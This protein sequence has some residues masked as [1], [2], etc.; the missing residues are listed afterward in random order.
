MAIIQNHIGPMP[1]ESL[2]NSKSEIYEAIK[3]KKTLVVFVNGW[4]GGT[5][6]TWGNFIDYILIDKRFRYCDIIFYN[7]KSI[8]R[9]I[10]VSSI[11]F[12]NTIEDFLTKSI[13]NNNNDLLYTN[14]IFVSH[15]TG[16][17]LCRKFMI[18]AINHNFSYVNFIKNIYFASAE[19]G[20][21]LQELFLTYSPSL[22]HLLTSYIIFKN[23][24]IEDLKADSTLLKN[25]QS[26]VRR[27]QYFHSSIIPGR[28]II[29]AELERIVNNIKFEMDPIAEIFYKK[30]HKR[31]C[32]PNDNFEQPLNILINEL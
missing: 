29:W 1:L 19:F 27:Y 25:H 11:E 30:T 5:T 16:A 23:P 17:I 26:I 24:S 6:R 22:L 14:I 8:S 4:G 2:Y 13:H 15:S 12:I 31:I 3:G 7:Y 10:F 9:Q 18:E 21:N 28:K 32:K 20:S